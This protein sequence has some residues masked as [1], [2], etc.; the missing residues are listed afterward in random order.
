MPRELRLAE[1]KTVALPDGMESPPGWAL[2]AARLWR[3]DFF[4]PMQRVMPKAGQTYTVGELAEFS[5][6]FQSMVSFVVN[7]SPDMIEEA[8]DLPPYFEETQGKISKNL[9][10]A[11]SRFLNRIASIK[12]TKIS[13]PPTSHQL[14]VN[15]RYSK[16]LKTY[17]VKGS[18]AYGLMNS[19]VSLYHCIWMF[20]PDLRDHFT[21][22]YIHGWL[23]K[24][25]G[26]SPADKTVEAVVTSI[27]KETDATLIAPVSQ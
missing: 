10:S 20:W 24:E 3:R 25:L 7:P 6:I 19:T 13:V 8:K 27:R 23:K 21:A 5:G 4:K 1:S 14:A 15:D 18:N 12:K 2:A 11:F 9:Q 17:P 16:G 26:K 22:P